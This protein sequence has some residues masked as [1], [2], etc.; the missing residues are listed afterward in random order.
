MTY[1]ERR[2][3]KAERLRRWGRAQV[4]ILRRMTMRCTA[5]VAASVILAVFTPPLAVAVVPDYSLP[6]GALNSQVTQANIAQ[7]I[8]VPG[9]TR[10]I[11]PPVQYTSALK[12][13]QMAERHLPGT[14]A[15][16]EEDHF[17][18]LELGGAPRD[19]RNLWPQPIVQAHLKDKQERALNRAVCA[20]RMTL[21]VAQ[22]KIKVPRT[23]R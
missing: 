19:V 7:T 8:C 9:W 12:R 23:W 14:S 3:A 6:P 4:P 16:Y 5:W 11:R 1:R 2:L 20:A 22:T 13:R 10:T 18:P 15:D 17:I 21:R